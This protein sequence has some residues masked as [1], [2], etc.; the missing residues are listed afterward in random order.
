MEKLL[1]SAPHKADVTVEVTLRE[2]HKALKGAEREVLSIV[3]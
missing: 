1:L 3:K 2:P